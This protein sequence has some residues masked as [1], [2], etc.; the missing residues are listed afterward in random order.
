MYFE[1]GGTTTNIGVIKDGRPAIDYS[2]VGGHRTYITSLDVRVLGVAGGSMIRL[3]KSGVSDVGPVPHILP[4]LTMQ[5][6]HR[7]K[8]SWNHSWNFSPQRKEIRRT[9]LQL[10]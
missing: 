7:K 10:N 5:S 2:V 8:K 9:M 3:S 1:V 6:L 4:D